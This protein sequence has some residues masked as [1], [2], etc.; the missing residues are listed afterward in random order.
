MRFDPGAWGVLNNVDPPLPINLGICFV[1]LIAVPTEYTPDVEPSGRFILR[2]DTDKYVNGFENQTVS[3]NEGIYGALNETNQHGDAEQ[4]YINASWD[5]SAFVGLGFTDPPSWAADTDY[6]VTLWSIIRQTETGIGTY[7]TLTMSISSEGLDQKAYYPSTSY[8]NNT[9]DSDFI[10]GSSD[11]W[12]LTD[13]EDILANLWLGWVGA[14]PSGEL[15]VTQVAFLCTPIVPSDY[16]PD[17][18]GFTDETFQEWITAGG[19]FMI[20]GFMG[21]VG[22]IAGAPLAIIFYKSG[23]SDGAGALAMAV[24]IIFVS[25]CFLLAG[26]SAYA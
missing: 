15:R 25:L 11:Y 2:P 9:H 14:T 5:K 17:T 20:F 16:V 4:S 24:G 6:K 26:L 13:L 3:D 21:A 18:G 23:R 8:T 7:Y 1:I 22:L 10:P 19:F 12:R